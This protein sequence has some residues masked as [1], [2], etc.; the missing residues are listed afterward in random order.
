MA[1]IDIVHKKRTSVWL[2]VALVIIALAVI[3]WMLAAAGQP[4]P[5]A[6]FLESAGP[7]PFAW[8]GQPMAPLAT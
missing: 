4:Q 7:Q 3:V 1:D 5:V 6:Q 8:H 2:W